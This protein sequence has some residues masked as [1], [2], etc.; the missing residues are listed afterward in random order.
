MPMVF[1]ALGILTF[2]VLP[3]LPDLD[4][5]EHNSIACT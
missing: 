5:I 4:P 3:D 2:T 1:L